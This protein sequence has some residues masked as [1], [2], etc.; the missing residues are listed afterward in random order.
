[1]DSFISNI[2]KKIDCVAPLVPILTHLTIRQS[3]LRSPP[4][5][6]PEVYWP[7]PKVRAE[8]PGLG[9]VRRSC[10]YLYDCSAAGGIS[11]CFMDWHLG[12]VLLEEL[13]AGKSWSR[14]RADLNAQMVFNF[15]G[16]QREGIPGTSWS[17]SQGEWKGR[18]VGRYSV[19]TD[20]KRCHQLQ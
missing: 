20:W 10:R 9:G 16:D 8:M 6:G 1:M 15:A 17:L 3:G 14:N 19:D 11:S 12:A 2:A 7:H 5:L 18:A 13:F 4:S